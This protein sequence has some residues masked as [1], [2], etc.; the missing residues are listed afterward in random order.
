[1]KSSVS[2]TMYTKLRKYL[3]TKTITFRTVLRR[4]GVEGVENDRILVHLLSL[5]KG[6]VQFQKDPQP[7]NQTRYESVERLGRG[8]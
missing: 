2:L 1:M 4:S 5:C 3:P 8:S 7:D 6:L